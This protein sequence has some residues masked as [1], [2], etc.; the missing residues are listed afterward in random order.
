[1]QKTHEKQ[2]LSQL[3]QLIVERKGQRP[4]SLS[5]RELSALL[6][7][8][9]WQAKVRTILQNLGG[10]SWS[11][12]LFL[13]RGTLE[14]LSATPPDGWLHYTYRFALDLMY[15]STCFDQDRA[16]YGD[17]AIF[18]FCLMQMIYAAERE[19]Q[20]IPE[21]IN[22]RMLSE[23]QLQ[24]EEAAAEYRKLKRVMQQEYVYEAMRLSQ[25]I[26]PYRT[27]EHITGVH[28]LALHC[29]TEMQQAG[30][31]VD[32]C[33]ISGASIVHDLGKYGCKAGERVPYL[34]YYYTDL[35]CNKRDLKNIGHIGA[36]HSVW[37]LELENLSA[38]SL[39]LIYADFRVKQIFEHGKE[40]TK[41]FSLKDSFEVIL[42]KLDQVDEAKQLRYTK[43][44][45][46]L[47]DF[48]D[49]M[50]SLGVDVELSNQK[51]PA[52]V[53]KEVALLVG[54]EPVTKLKLMGVEHNIALMH[55]LSSDRRFGNIL[56]A[57]R[58][59]KKWDNIRAYLGVFD[60]YFT[61]LDINQKVQLLDFLYEL[62]MNKEG[63]IRRQAATLLGNIIAK[64]DI[65]YKKELPAEVVPDDEITAL[66]MWKKYLDLILNPDYKLTAQHKSWIG[67]TLKIVIL[68]F[69]KH[70][71]PS[72]RRIFMAELISHYSDEI[73]DDKTYADVLLEEHDV[74]F[75]LLD[76]LNYL[77]L[78]Y[79][80]PEERSRLIRFAVL[81]A[82]SSASDLRSVALRTLQY[83]INAD[84]E[85]LPQDRESILRSCL[86]S[87][88]SDE[89]SIQVLEQH[90]LAALDAKDKKEA[91][92][93]TGDI[94][95]DV[96][97]DNLKLATPWVVKTLN[98]ALL[99]DV[100]EENP[101]SPYILHI[102]T[103]FTNL[104]KISERVVVRHRAGSALLHIAPFLTSDQRNEIAMELL[105]G[106]EVG[107]LEFSKYIP[108]YL[109][110]FALWLHTEEL[111]ELI[112]QLTE[113][114]SSA[115]TGIVSVAMETI[116]VI[117]EGYTDYHTRF[118]ESTEKFL[119]RRDKL[120]GI[121]LK[122]LVGHRSA[123]QQEAML[124]IGRHIFASQTMAEQTKREIFGRCSKK[125]LTLLHDNTGD[126]LT[127]FYRAAA[128]NHIYRFISECEI[129]Y[130]EFQLEQPD[131]VAFFP[132]TFD[133]FSLSHKGIVE[134]IL[135]N[136]F[137]VMLAIDEFS[138]SKKTQPH[139]I[140]RRIA[141]M[142][143]A[144]QFHVY[145]YPDSMPVNLA[146]AEDLQMLKNSFPGRQVYIVVG[147]DVI[148]HASSY[149][150]EPH[151]G[152]V[153]G[154]DHI[155]FLRSANA[156]TAEMSLDQVELSGITGEVI[157]LS[158]PM[159]LEEISSSRI[160]ENIDHNR[161]ISNQVDSMVQEYIY[162]NS[163]YLREPQYKLL[164]FLPTSQF[165]TIPR[166]DKAELY[167][168]LSELRPERSEANRTV[169]ASIVHR[170]DTVILMKDY[171]GGKTMGLV[172]MHDV[173]VSEL[174]PLLKN[175]TLTDQIR[176]KQAGRVLV[177]SEIFMQKDDPLI[178]QALLVEALDKGLRNGCTHAIFYAL[179][180]VSA[181]AIAVLERQGFVVMPSGDNKKPL[182]IVDIREPLVLIRNIE[183]ALKTPFSTSDSVLK[184]AH[185]AHCNLQSAM[186]KLKPGHL[187]L[188]LDSNLMHQRLIERIAALNGVPALPTTP[189]Q[190]GPM[191]CVPFGK[192]LRGRRIPNTVTKTLHTEKVFEP[193]LGSFAVEA[194]PN[195]SSLENQIRTIRS[196]QRPVIMVD[197]LLHS[198]H[199]MKA[200]TPLF[201]AQNIDI[202]MVLVGILSGRGQDM[203]DTLGHKTEGIY[204]V[205]N[206]D[207]WCVESTLY[208]FIGGD[209]VRRE[210]HA[211]NNLLPSINLILPYASIGI[212]NHFPREAVF[213]YSLACMENARNIMQALESEYL[214]RF[215]RNLTLNRLSEVVILPVV[216][217][218]GSCMKYDYNLTAS[219]F[220]ENDIELLLRSA[221]LYTK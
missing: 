141:N 135:A 82:E 114:I 144:D 43:V 176:R 57:A 110:Q 49:Y 34:H 181:N 68:S 216:P 172:V 119:G 30:A 84:L 108:Q 113:L 32:L 79:C 18:L 197:D 20:L 29:A 165:C 217:D 210:G 56:E 6:T 52:P 12:A 175:A 85:I 103:H 122:G 192:V 22:I 200:L 180:D 205:P 26:T 164:H 64:F 8:H 163:L 219:V 36:N 96:F 89:I 190:L 124:I 81:A 51:A 94:I 199:R 191:M 41:L 151:Q 128:L 166:P 167:A 78:E 198:S 99:L 208:P 157:H 182:Y 117:L 25:E 40:C 161:D 153:H 123:V 193:D 42:S 72:D 168:W 66:S 148:S 5:K 38:E 27:L 178:A 142:S 109:G 23:D 159:Y 120:I 4:F 16:E 13:S 9:D 185:K 33:L 132:G 116:G 19:G 221:N 44:Y 10:T 170:E 17:G 60:E 146:N 21:N 93:I 140:R 138:W 11:E 45:A 134:A 155:I 147:S 100:A 7:A 69:F 154:F 186:T 102:A 213:Q 188:S 115:N 50:R 107:E 150:A 61:Y 65:S 206:L 15:P 130:G 156:E 201:E 215:G 71:A 24:N 133:P 203:M 152:S 202:E 214:Q 55:R 90:I 53:A 220:L 35:W 121:L 211:V 179:E 195:Y 92:E 177:L 31:P 88:T 127:F 196:F 83:I 54:N 75:V 104:I 97:L 39:L 2:F 48:E 28:R 98:V 139:L 101:N 137:E 136:G 187:V 74:T 112:Y 86:S 184:A 105:K 118:A 3:T 207:S 106:L 37:D 111:D 126:E 63:D 59:E 218:K 158:L 194:Y 76:A 58:S 169:A 80:T 95:S 174:L 125:L 87:H 91:P 160:R 143:L 209:T 129:C 131:K 173:H 46:K 171:S 77:P 62:L 162:H 149:L 47:K 183:T 204:Y 14:A 70:C 67:F 212:H 145:I 73:S 189:Q 1:M